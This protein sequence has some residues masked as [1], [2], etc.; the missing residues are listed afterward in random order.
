M[1]AL[2]VDRIQL[3]PA[4]RLVSRLG[5]GVMEEPYRAA[6][7]PVTLSLTMPRQTDVSDAGADHLRVR[8]GLWK[9]E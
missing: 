6:M 1:A 5:A 3:D 7:H 8:G 2:I 9:P 4:L